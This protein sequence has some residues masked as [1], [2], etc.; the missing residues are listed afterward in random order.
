MVGVKLGLATGAV[1]GLLIGLLAAVVGGVLTSSLPDFA[2]F[3]ANTFLLLL[4]VMP[5]FFYLNVM[6]DPDT[7]QDK[8]FARRNGV[9]VA[10]L[11]WIPA[12]VIGLVLFMTPVTMAPITLGKG[13]TFATV[14]DWYRQIFDQLMGW[15]IALV[16]VAT[17]VGFGVIGHGVSKR[18]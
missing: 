14:S 1:C 9:V 16:A 8:M 11:A 6:N 15:R 18:P 4:A 3:I 17:L 12:L 2:S 13:V 5:V 7:T 10:A